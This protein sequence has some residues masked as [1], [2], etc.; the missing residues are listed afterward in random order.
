MIQSKDAA[1]VSLVSICLLAGCATPTPASGPVV[2]IDVPPDGL[3]VPANQPVRVEGH[4]AYRGGVARIEIWVGG[5]LH[6]VQDDPPVSGGLAHFDQMWMPPG[7]GEYTVEVIAVSGDGLASAPD[8]V[9]LVVGEQVA[10]ASPTPVATP[11][12][13]EEP[14]TATPVPTSTPVPTPT[15]PPPTAT[16]PAVI[17]FWA[18]SEQVAAGSCTTLH[19]RVEQVQ[20]VFFDDYGVTGEET[21]QVCPCAD[22]THTLRVILNDGSE[23]QRSITIHVTGSCAPADSVGPAAPAQLKPLDEE[24]FACIPDTI[25]RWSAASDPSGVAEYRV[26]VQRHAGDNNWQPVTGSPWTGVSALELLVD[27]ECGW[28][29]RWRV[30]AV[31]GVGNVG[32]F[33]GWFRFDVLLM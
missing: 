20:G 31:D 17:E 12:P 28:Y 16:P 14:P 32:S 21:R 33:S 3:R 4:A 30:Q 11:V 13:T 15:P 25:L 1:L 26:E 10:E 22:E 24:A 7:S 8:S 19:W 9:R 5:E 23:E 29:Y 18:D 6:L 2:W 27:V